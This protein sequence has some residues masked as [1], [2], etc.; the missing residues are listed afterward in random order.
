M[1]SLALSIMSNAH[2]HVWHAVRNKN[3]TRTLRRINFF[4]KNVK[5]VDEKMKNTVL[6]IKIHDD[7]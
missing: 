2:A 5:T 4:M 1:F 3:I 7:V 6:R